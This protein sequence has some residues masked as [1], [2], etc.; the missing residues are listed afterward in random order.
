MVRV[1]QRNENSNGKVQNEKYSSRLGKSLK[2]AGGT[3][4]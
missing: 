3:E 4:I 1:P 2:K